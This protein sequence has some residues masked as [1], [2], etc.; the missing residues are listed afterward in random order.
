[1]KFKCLRI[2][3]CLLVAVMIVSPGC[4]QQ[5]GTPTP[6]NAETPVKGPQSSVDGSSTGGGSFGDESALTILRWASK[7]LSDQIRNSSPEIYKNLP[8]GWTQEKLA[9]VIANV[10]PNVKNQETYQVPEVNRYG[11]RLMFNYGKRPDGSPFITATKLFIDA[12]ASHDVN[13]QPKQ[14]FYYKIEELKLKLAHEAAHLLGLGLSKETDMSEARAFSKALLASLDSD[15]FEC[16]PKNPPP[17]EVYSAHKMNR[18]Q[19]SPEDVN[20]SKALFQQ[21]STQSYVFNRPT[22]KAAIPMS[23]YV[24][25][26]PSLPMLSGPQNALGH[27]NCQAMANKNHMT[28]GVISVFAPKSYDEKF[29]IPTIQKSIFEGIREYAVQGESY[30]SWKKIDL[31]KAVPSE[32]GYKSNYKYDREPDMNNQFSEYLDFK[33]LESTA[34]KIKLESYPPLEQE[35]WQY[36]RSDGKS[37]IEIQLSDEKIVDANLVILKNYNNWYERETPENLNMQVPLT[38]IRSFKPL[39]LP[40]KAN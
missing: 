19:G 2:Q 15:N 26:D 4:Q 17:V 10:E 18:F 25:C 16:L 9:E 40:P 31:R 33:V 7:D 30:F 6:T 39:Q 38:C 34:Q 3:F 32:N 23:T 14:D 36:Y 13:A 11:Q 8:N 28:S 24:N 29:W 21:K 12:Y 35:S 1:M 22:G 27:S 37:R 5:K 20:K